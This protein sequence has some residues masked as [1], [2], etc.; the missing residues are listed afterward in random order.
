MNASREIRKKQ[1]V[2]AT[3]ACAPQSPSVHTV[4]SPQS[5]STSTC[6]YLQIPP[7]LAQDVPPKIAWMG[8]IESIVFVILHTF[9]MGS[10]G[11]DAHH[12]VQ[13]CGVVK[14]STSKSSCLHLFAGSQGNRQTTK[15]IATSH[16]RVSSSH[17]IKMSCTCSEIIPIICFFLFL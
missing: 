4:H 5:P 15:Q 3:L 14:A 6:T 1:P 2:M 10:N 7:P 8:G 17:S 16:V 13:T 9:T 12:T 11:Q